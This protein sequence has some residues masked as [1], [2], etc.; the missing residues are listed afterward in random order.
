MPKTMKAPTKVAPREKAKKASDPFAIHREKLL[1]KRE[2]M[3]AQYRKD[4]RMGQETNDEPTEDIVDR[5]NNSYSRELTFS[6][7][8]G[9]RSL[10][11]QIEEALKRL[12][13]GTF[14]H[15]A[16]CG[17]VIG[18]QRLEALPWARLCIDCQEL[19]EKGMLSEP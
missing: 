13:A 19:L 14:G 4:L 15:C 17:E 5:A 16:H 7:S 1:R 8:D 2:D 9:E 18:S 12:D 3:L 6:L 10:L 11:L